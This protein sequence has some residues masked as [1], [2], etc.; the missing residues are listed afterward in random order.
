MFVDKKRLNYPGDA[1]AEASQDLNRNLE[2]MA[3]VMASVRQHEEELR[4]LQ[5]IKE[6]VERDIASS[7]AALLEVAGAELALAARQRE[8]EA[9][10]PLGDFLTEVKSERADPSLEELSSRLR[11][12]QP[13]DYNVTLRSG[14]HF[15]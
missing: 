5:G 13:E 12:D 6:M 10:E 14:V 7:R 15:Q 8:E 11:G 1:L 2:R 3:E 9:R 4:R